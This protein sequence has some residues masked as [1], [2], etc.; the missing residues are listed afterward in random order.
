MR[1]IVAQCCK[2]FRIMEGD[3]SPAGVLRNENIL[4]ALVAVD[5]PC[6][7][8]RIPLRDS[9][10]GAAGVVISLPKILNRSV[11]SA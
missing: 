2:V 8:R 5:V 1:G 11:G 10:V 6:R 4:L 3:W 7:S 9:Y